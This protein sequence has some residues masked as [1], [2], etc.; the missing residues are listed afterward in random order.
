[1][2]AWDERTRNG[3]GGRAGA[4]ILRADYALGDGDG[5]DS[6]DC[7]AD[8]EYH[9]HCDAGT[10]CCCG[11]SE[12]AVADQYAEFDCGRRS[13]DA[14]ADAEYWRQGWTWRLWGTGREADCPEYAGCAGDG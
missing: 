12:C 11:A 9:E 5:E 4:G 3:F 10:G 7:E 14:G 8:A 13:G 2:P 6:G 1:M